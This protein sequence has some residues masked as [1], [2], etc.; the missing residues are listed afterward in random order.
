MVDHGVAPSFKGDPVGAIF[1]SVAL[2]LKRVQQ[3]GFVNGV[4]FG[5]RGCWR[6]DS[7]RYCLSQLRGCSCLSLDLTSGLN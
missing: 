6:G 7:Y 5:L 2:V 4:S 1:N 3:G